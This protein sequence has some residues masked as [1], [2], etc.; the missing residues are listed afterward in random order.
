[1]KKCPFCAEEIQE[2]AIVCKHCGRELSGKI[3]KK[4][5]GRSSGRRM[6]L[7]GGV[8]IVVGLVGYMGSC[9]IGLTETLSFYGWLIVAG[10]V[11]W[12][13]GRFRAA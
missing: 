9:S 3:Q 13:I 2:A 4:E 5:E 6:S 10:F 11:L 8:L 1:L 7:L 12:L